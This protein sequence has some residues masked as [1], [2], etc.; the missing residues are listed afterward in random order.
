MSWLERLLHGEPATR[1]PARGDP[2]RV[3]AVQAVLDE[4]RPIFEADGGSVELV[5]VEEDFVE[6]RLHGACGSCYASDTTLHAA[7]EP[8]LKEKCPWVCGVRRV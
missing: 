4:L 6:V 8:K 1:G 5:A 3:L 2:E 7:L